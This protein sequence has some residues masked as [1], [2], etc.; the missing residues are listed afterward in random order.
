MSRP[1]EEMISNSVSSSSDTTVQCEMR[2]MDTNLR[3]ELQTVHQND[4]LNPPFL[5]NWGCEK[6]DLSI[7]RV[8][9]IIK[10]TGSERHIQCLH[11]NCTLY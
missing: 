11:S 6:R 2:G 9:V 3:L 4:G 1:T 5:D 10:L 7:R 8:D